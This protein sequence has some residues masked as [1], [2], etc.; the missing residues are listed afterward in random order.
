YRSGDVLYDVMKL[1]LPSGREIEA[2]LRSLG[3]QKSHYLLLTLHRAGAVDDK[4]S[5]QRFIKLTAA[6]QEPTIFPLHPRTRRRLR[7]FGL[8]NKLRSNRHLKLIDPCGYREMLALTSGAR[9]VLTDS[10]GLQRE[11][12]R[13]RVPVLLLRNAT[14]WV[15]IIKAG[16]GLVVGDDVDLLRRGSGKKTFQFRDRAFCRTGAAQR[17]ARRL[18]NLS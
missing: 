13:L 4:V 16:G 7:Q 1:A 2:I 18:T 15:E 10:G 11:A 8:M 3:L 6:I 9:M 17:I 5:L 14:E 12:Y